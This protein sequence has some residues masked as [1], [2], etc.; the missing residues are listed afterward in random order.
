MFV[1]WVGRGVWF[2]FGLGIEVVDLS[3]GGWG[4][5][6]GCLGMWFMCVVLCVCDLEFG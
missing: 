1:F 5:I 2:F 6:V 3:L 4:F